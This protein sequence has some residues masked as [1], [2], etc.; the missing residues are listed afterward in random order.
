MVKKSV[1]PSADGKI[2]EIVYKGHHNHPRPSVMCPRDVPT[3]Y[4]P[5]S[6]YY[7]YV[8]SEMYIPGTSIP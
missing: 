3:G 5:D 1:T 4:I 6:Q 7:S 2:S 8:P